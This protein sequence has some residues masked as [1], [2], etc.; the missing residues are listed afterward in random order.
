VCI[1]SL[2]T[3]IVAIWHLTQNGYEQFHEV[4][5][6]K[7][8]DLFMQRPLR[9]L[10][11]LSLVVA[12]VAALVATG[13]FLRPPPTGLEPGPLVVMTAFAPDPGDVRSMLLDQWNRLN[14]NNRA[15]FDYAPANF[16]QQHDR[17]VGDVKP[18]GEQRADIY[19]LDIVWMAEFT[20]RRYIQPLDE[21]R[22]GERD[23]GDF[24]P[25][26]LDTCYHDG[27]PWAL[28]FNSDVGLIFHRS[29]IPGVAPPRTWDDYFGASAKATVAAARTSQ[30]GIEA[31][32]AAQLAP[33]DEMLTITALEAIWAAGGRL[34]G[35][36]GQPALTAD[37]SRVDF[38]PADLAGIENLATASRDPDL[39]LTKDDEA[40]KAT[41]ELASQTFGDGRTLYMRNWP[42]ARDAVGDKVP[43]A[44]T[45]T[46][47][48][49]L[50][51]SAMRRG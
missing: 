27:K 10:P 44:V 1:N 32:N 17:M 37:R 7:K 34:I 33:E 39:V 25:K 4:L 26:V 15:S 43:F 48:T 22:L 46:C 5:R 9:L 6:R 41:A 31:A 28:P 36:N 16:D 18:E 2:P 50:P 3:V 42:I 14:P 51:N 23:L 20:T 35:P 29:D 38:G 11:R 8:R 47:T 24:V 21:S 30:P 45:A 13:V 40:K 19:V 49:L 12:T